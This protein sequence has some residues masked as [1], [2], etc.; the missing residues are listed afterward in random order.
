MRKKNQA[1]STTERSHIDAVVPEPVPEEPRRRRDER[2]WQFCAALV[3]VIVVIVG[4]TKIQLARN[5]VLDTRQILSYPD[6]PFT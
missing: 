2:G 4:L 5:A 3:V 1:K 6:F